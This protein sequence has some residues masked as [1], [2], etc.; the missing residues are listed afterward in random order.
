[1]EKSCKSSVESSDVLEGYG[2]QCLEILPN[3]TVLTPPP[4]MLT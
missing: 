3:L 2:P 4:R 1:M